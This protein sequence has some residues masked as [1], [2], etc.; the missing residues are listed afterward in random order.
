MMIK[1]Q[2]KAILTVHHTQVFLIKSIFILILQHTAQT[3]GRE[4]DKC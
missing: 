3:I 4:V 1:C 2:Y